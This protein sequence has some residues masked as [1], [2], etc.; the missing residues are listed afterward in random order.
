MNNKYQ[1]SDE[2]FRILSPSTKKNRTRKRNQ[3]TGSPTPDPITDKLPTKERR[4]PLVKTVHGPAMTRTPAVLVAALLAALL[5]PATSRPEAPL[6]GGDLG[7]VAASS[8][9][10]PC[11]PLVV[12]SLLVVWL[13]RW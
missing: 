8:A 13:V 6:L 10:A 3:E 12:A 2:P 7:A 11:A 1:H 4:L 5:R 9:A